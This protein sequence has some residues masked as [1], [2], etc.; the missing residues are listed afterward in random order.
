M[1]ADEVDGIESKVDPWS[2]GLWET[3]EKAVNG[4]DSVTATAAPVTPATLPTTPLSS[5]TQEINTNI[6]SAVAEDA[7]ATPIVEDVAKATTE[8][9]LSQL[10]GAVASSVASTSAKDSP[11]PTGARRTSLEG[12]RSSASNAAANKQRSAA[13]MSHKPSS[14]MF[15]KREEATVARKV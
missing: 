9:A 13:L 5:T 7:A 3:L 14:V 4:K 12:P 15:P 10:A 11:R 8:D 2:E 1:E 6:T